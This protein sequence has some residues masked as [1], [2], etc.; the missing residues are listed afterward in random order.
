MEDLQ[1]SQILNACALR[2]DGYKYQEEKSYDHRAAIDN[3]FEYGQWD[4]EP[5]EKLTT[6]FLL[7]RALSKWDLQYE[8]ED[9]KF[10]MAFRTLFL[11]CVELKI[12]VKSRIEDY[13]EEWK[14]EYDPRLEQVKKY[15]FDV[16][17]RTKY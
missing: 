1:E 8:A 4:I 12:P 7:Q 3:F 16:H 17:K 9:S 13:Y 6:F 11:E 14:Q 5:I 10:Y 2:F 15:I